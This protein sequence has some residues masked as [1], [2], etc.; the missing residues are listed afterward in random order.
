MKIFYVRIGDRYGVE[1]EEYLKKKLPDYELHAITSPF[2]DGVKLQWNKMYPMSLDINEPVCVI[3]I[4]IELINDYK[5]LF[6][7]HIEP[8]QFLSIPSWWKDSPGYSI[9]GGFFKY[10]PK[11]CR[12]I[13]DKFINNVDHWQQ[14]YINNGTTVGPVN[15]EQHFVEDSVKEKLELIT[16]PEAWVARWTNAY[17]MTTDQMRKWMYDI[18]KKYTE[19]S[20]NEYLHLGDFHEDVKFIHYTHAQNKPNR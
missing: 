10:Y 20:G 7:Y 5:Q 16:C 2:R 19:A 14:Y 1:Y 8:G 6:D 18:S 3:D 9:N 11:D 15:G 13:Y 4:D 17:N 12:Y